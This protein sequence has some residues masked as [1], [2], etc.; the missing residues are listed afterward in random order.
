MIALT[1][2]RVKF[3]CADTLGVN[4][5]TIGVLS[6]VLSTREKRLARGPKRPRGSQGSRQEARQRQWRR[7]IAAGGQGQRRS[8]WR[9]RGADRHAVDVLPVIEDI[10]AAGIGTLE[11]KL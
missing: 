8:R 5:S 6:E 9:H 3:V 4:N 1:F 7:S 11:G 2:V 10:R